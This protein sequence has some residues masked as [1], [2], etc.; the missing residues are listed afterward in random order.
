[1]NEPGNRAQRSQTQSGFSTWFDHHLYSLMASLGRAVRKPWATL[2]TIGVMAVA[3]SLPLGLGLILSNVERFT[4]SV[5]ASR[6]ISVFLKPDTQ[7]E[8]ARSL[9]D[10]LRGPSHCR[11]GRRHRLRPGAFVL[12]EF[13]DCEQDRR[14]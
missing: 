4:G 6:E 1:M 10:E 13:E 3:L 2:L 7:L 5:E 14:G 12:V 9:A 11:F 8:R